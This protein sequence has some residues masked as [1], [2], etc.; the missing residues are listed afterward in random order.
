MVKFFNEAID[1]IIKAWYDNNMLDWTLVVFFL[2][3]PIMTCQPVLQKK[4]L[5]DL[6]L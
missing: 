6:S 3:S 2:A 4:K 1:K 5:A